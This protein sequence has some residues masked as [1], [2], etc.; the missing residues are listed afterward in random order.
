M[1][2]QPHNTHRTFPGRWPRFGRHSAAR[3]HGERGQT[4]VEFALVLPVLLAVVFGILAFGR[5]MNYDEQATH[6]A[7][8][9]ARYAAVDQPPPNAGAQTLLQWV[10]SEAD[11]P[12]LAKGTGSVSSA[13]Q[14][15]VSTP[16][17][18]TV[19][20]D[21]TVKTWFTFSW[22]PVLGINAA[23]TRITRTATMRIEVP[24]TDPFFASAPV[25]T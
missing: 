18:T 23:S 4:L 3:L 2:A 6:L 24:P 22:L 8:V 14:V 5:A 21:L 15:C 17:G 7:N 16:D 25:C 20:S 9:A 12:E 10:R 19:G 11:S 13:L 1:H